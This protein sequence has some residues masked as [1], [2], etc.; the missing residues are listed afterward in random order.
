MKL[1]TDFNHEVYHNETLCEPIEWSNSWYNNNWNGEKRI[2]LLG[3]STMRMVRS[4]LQN[5]LN[6]PIDLFA[7]SSAFRESLF[8]NQLD[9]FLK[10]LPLDNFKYQIIFVQFG[11]HSILGADGNL[12]SDKDYQDFKSGY[13]SLLDYLKQFCH[14]IIVESAFYSVIKQNTKLKYYANKFGLIQERPDISTNKVIEM[15]NQI[16]KQ[17][18]NEKKCYFFDIAEYMNQRK[19]FRRC[20]EI[21]YY[22]NGINEIVNQMAL[23]IKKYI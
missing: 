10:S 22:N 18:A 11:F 2:L 16:A 7:S 19:Q 21:H 12:Y 5:K 20:D 1:Y 23:L 9:A 14:V 17:I 3:D 8:A 4:R 15:K 6:L 13:E